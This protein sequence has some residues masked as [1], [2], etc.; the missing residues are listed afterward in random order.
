MG[1]NKFE[2]QQ[3][4]LSDIKL[5]RNKN[6]TQQESSNAPVFHKKGS[7]V[8]TFSHVQE[9]IGHHRTLLKGW[10]G[11][12]ILDKLFCSLNCTY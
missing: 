12:T 8:T 2:P 3:M 1:T 11:N 4:G 9:N 6:T 5:K 7:K 10:Q